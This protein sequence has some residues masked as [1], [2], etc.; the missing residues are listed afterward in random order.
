MN[1]PLPSSNGMGMIAAWNRFW[2]S[3]TDPT[4]LGLIRICVGILTV[5]VH[6]IYSFDLQE[7]VGKDAWVSTEQA[8]KHRRDVPSLVQPWTWDD[9][10]S[11]TP[12]PTDE[13]ERRKFLTDMA[14]KLDV[15]LQ[16]LPVDPRQRLQALELAYNQFR[17]RHFGL[18][19]AS[20][21]NETR[22][23]SEEIK[24]Y[25]RRF[26]VDPRKAYSRGNLVWSVWFHVT[27][28]RW[29]RVIHTGIVLVMV[30]FTLGF[31]TR[32]TSVL[33]WLG[34]I[35]YI[36]RS[37]PTLFGED[38]MMNLLLLYLMVGP[39]GAALSLDRW[40]ARRRARKNG[41]GDLA[42][43]R[44]APS[45]GANFTLRLIQINLCFIYGMAGMSKLQG[46]SWWGGTAIWLTLANYSFAP[47]GNK[48]YREFLG[49]LTEHR[50]LWEA[51]MHL[52]VI[53][54]LVVE[55]GGPF[56]LW[57]RKTRWFLIIVAILMHAGISV[58]MGLV[59][60]QL[61]ML[62]MLLAFFPPETV[63]RLVDGTAALFSR[64]REK[65]LATATVSPQPLALSH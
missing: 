51:V 60:F 17:D 58:L 10:V 47:L 56:L 59:V 35:S 65:L 39:S 19:P 55:L 15:D 5:Y 8:N 64:R 23:R 3:P 50:W 63:R 2:F 27:D 40:L 22:E 34:A 26:G 31:C 61:Y 12:V 16:S 30:L 7:I 4:A 9:E 54:T 41:A 52:G 13:D 42:L 24:D 32:V 44:P 53:H 28:P 18:D 6:I 21:R 57:P 45:V 37:G 36:Q 49:Y 25:V 38:T 11:E 62:C 46:G 48:L 1:T 43:D 33:T 20:L 14:D 29:M